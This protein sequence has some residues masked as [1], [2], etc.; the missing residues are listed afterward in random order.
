MTFNDLRAWADFNRGFLEQMRA[1]KR[2][3]KTVE[4]AAAEWTPP[5]G[6]TAPQAARLQSNVRVVFN[7]LP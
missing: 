3:G 7:E 6:F 5:A 1:A 2:A 4:Q